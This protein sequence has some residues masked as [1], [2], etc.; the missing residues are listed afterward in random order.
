M[1]FLCEWAIALINHTPPTDD[2]FCLSTGEVWFS[3]F[4]CHRGVLGSVSCGGGGVCI[5]V[6]PQGFGS[7]GG[8]WICVCPQGDWGVSSCGFEV[9]VLVLLSVCRGKVSFKVQYKS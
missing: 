6:C 1:N 4:V 9:V 8:V 7:C 3:G 2:N 5:C